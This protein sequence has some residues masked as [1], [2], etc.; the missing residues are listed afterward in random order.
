[1]KKKR[2]RKG[3]GPMLH[4]NRMDLPLELHLCPSVIAKLRELEELDRQRKLK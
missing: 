2:K 3:F 1:M 4:H